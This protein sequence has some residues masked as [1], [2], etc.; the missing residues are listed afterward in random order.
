MPLLFVATKAHAEV[1]PTAVTVDYAKNL[2]LYLEHLN[3]GAPGQQDLLRVKSYEGKGWYSS[4]EVTEEDYAG[5]LTV[6]TNKLGPGRSPLPEVYQWNVG[7]GISLVLGPTKQLVS[8]GQA[9]Y[10]DPQFVAFS[11]AAKESYKL[12]GMLFI[13]NRT[14][15]GRVASTMTPVRPSIPRNIGSSSLPSIVVTPGTSTGTGFFVA[16]DGHFLTSYHIVKGKGDISVLI[17]G[18]EY[19]ARVM[20][21]SE[22]V[23]LALLKVEGA[24]ALA[25]PVV[26]VQNV[27]LGEQVFTLGFPNMEIQGVQPKYTRGNISSLTGI[28]DDPLLMQI[29]VPIQP[30]NSGGPLFNE[31]GQVVG[32]I[33]ATLNNNTALRNTGALPQNVNYAVR[34]DR[35]MEFLATNKIKAVTNSQKRTPEEL[36]RGI[37]MVIAKN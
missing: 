1:T 32:V 2:N 29:S 35:I 34:A 18:K 20:A 36:T 15:D 26:G 31:K 27:S 7:K 9:V 17:D 30:G 10:L 37:A 4:V 24:T 8:E 3:T 23:D 12:A 16:S 22:R 25:L 6:I 13:V 5:Y 33:A 14:I 21:S 28:K 11:D 19:A